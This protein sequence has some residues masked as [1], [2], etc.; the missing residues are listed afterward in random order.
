M[1]TAIVSFILIML[2]AALAAADVHVKQIVKVDPYYDGGPAGG[3]TTE[4]DLWFGA[5]KIAAI[6]QG[7]SVLFDSAAGRLTVINPAD[8][9]YCIIALPVNRDSVLEA[10]YKARIDRWYYDGGVSKT[11]ET[12]GIGGK[13]CA[14]YAGGQWIQLGEDR[15]SELE[16][17]YWLATDVP[18]DWKPFIDMQ[19]AIL[20]L[21]NSSDAYL[22]G[23]RSLQGFAL[24]GEIIIYNRGQQVV[25]RLAADVLGESAPPAGCYEIPS[26][27]TRRE[28][29]PRDMF[30]ILIQLV[31]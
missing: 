21:A 31:Y 9:T 29:L 18:F 3:T 22:A 26:Y 24:A 1:R 2:M 25:S 8:S 20:A 17:T 4:T 27:C 28:R 16:K 15:Y 19:L 23:M 5:G 12:K 14:A 11:G 6:G 13:P 10:E 30:L 7:G